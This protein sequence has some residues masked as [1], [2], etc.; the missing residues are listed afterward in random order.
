M[1]SRR[2]INRLLDN[3]PS[4]SRVLSRKGQ[5]RSPVRVFAPAY[6]MFLPYIPF[7]ISNT[8][9]HN[10]VF[11]RFSLQIPNSRR[12]SPFSTLS[13]YVFPLHIYIN[14][15]SVYRTTYSIICLHYVCTLAIVHG[16]CKFSP[17]VEP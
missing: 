15:P 6:V 11:T 1:R 2:S 13:I 3:D 9:P 4:R 14:M 17:S 8:H 10:F 12:P 5:V 16:E 7:R